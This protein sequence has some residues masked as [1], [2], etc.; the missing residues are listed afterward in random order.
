MKSI[1][2]LF[3][4][5]LLWG[6][7]PSDEAHP[8]ISSHGEAFNAGDIE[9]M[10]SLQHP[11]IEWF[12]VDGSEMRLEI[13]GRDALAEMLVAYRNSNP[14]VT[15]TMSDWSQNGPYIAVTETASWTVK[16]GANRS[17]SATSVYEMEEGLIRRVWYFPAVSD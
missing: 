7:S 5:F 1:V 4:T 14:T 9:A 8:V 2:I 16:D 15:G 12:A 10:S 3:V 17:Q 6:C 11:D 13:A